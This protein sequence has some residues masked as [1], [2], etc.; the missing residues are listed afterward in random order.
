MYLATVVVL[1][2]LLTV[3]NLFLTLGVIRRLRNHTDQF[4]ELGRLMPRPEPMISAGKHPS[5]FTATTVDGLAVSE[6]S[7]RTG[8]LVGF[9]SPTCGSCEEWVP[10]FVEAARALPGG[11][12]AALAVVVADSPSAGAEMVAKLRDV[13]MVVTEADRGP[14]VEAF[15]ATGYP[16]MCRLGDDGAVITNRPVDVVAVPVGA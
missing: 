11:P 6:A 9:F 15:E 3:F 13:A 5:P 4:T 1:C 10:R 2:V 14:V 8:G 12:K 16:A 7:L